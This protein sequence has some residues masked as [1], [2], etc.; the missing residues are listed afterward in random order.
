MAMT[1]RERCQV[2][3]DGAVLVLVLVLVVLKSL[4]ETAVT[5]VEG[6]ITWQSRGSHVGVG[7]RET[8]SPGC[9]QRVESRDLTLSSSHRRFNDQPRMLALREGW[10]ISSHADDSCRLTLERVARFF[11]SSAW[12]IRASRNL[13]LA[14]SGHGPILLSGSLPS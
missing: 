11:I 10:V 8:R 12:L 6:V 5:V 14:A 9:C 1:R 4:K 13:H 7:S 3:G 2:H